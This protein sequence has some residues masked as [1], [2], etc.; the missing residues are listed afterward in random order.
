MKRIFYPNSIVV[1]GVSENPDNLARNI[2]FNLKAFNYQGDLYAVGRRDGK[3]AGITIESTLDRIPDGL[4]LAVI[5]TPAETVPDLMEACGRKGIQRV[6][7]ESSGFSEFSPE[8]HR[9]E[10]QLKATARRWD[11]RFVG[12]NCISVVNLESGVCLPFARI[13]PDAVRK[14]PVSIVSQSGGISITYFDRLSTVGVGVN[15]VVSIGNKA[16][17]D[18]G[19]Y[20]DYLL[21][22]PGTEIV[23]LYL[24]SIQDGRRLISQA[25]ASEKPIIIHKA[26]RGTASQAVAFSH[27]AALADDDRVVSAAFK[28]AGILRSDTIPE[29][30]MIARGLALPPVRG[31]NLAVISRSG[32]H[33]VVAAD[34][35]ERYDFKLA[36]L[37]E[38]FTQSVR[39]MFRADVI[40]LTNPIDLGVIFDFDLYAQIVEQCLQ[41][42]SP[43][44]VLLVN[45]YGMR[46][47]ESAHRLA[48]RV[49]AIM[50]KSG[51]P[52]A[53]CT[54]SRTSQAQE[55]RREADMPVFFD[56]ETAVRALA[57][58]RDWHRWK[59]GHARA[60]FIENLTAEPASEEKITHGTLTTDNVFKLCQRAGIAVAPWEVVSEP[61]HA[62]GA[63]KRLGFPVVLKMLAEEVVHK[64]DAGG[65]ILDLGDAAE[66]EQG[67]E[68]IVQRFRE[69]APASHLPRILVQ[70][71]IGEG[72]EVILGAKR[73]ASFGP[74]VMFGMG[75]IHVE[76]FDDVS[77]RVAPLTQIDAEAMIDEVR[78]S[79]VLDG[80][81]GKL[82]AC[83]TALVEALLAISAL[84]VQNPLLSEFEINPL[85]VTA[86]GALAVD[87]RAV[88]GDSA[89]E[90]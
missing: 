78:G 60:P 58:S 8:G 36:P 11:I 87:A 39:S 23:C 7:I 84:M 42:I 21:Q 86:D 82:P 30:V 2:I 76:I 57:A 37:P 64:T 63:A 41:A 62:A 48:K 22:D 55:L 27:T 25:R 90:E 89:S 65:V 46:E 9:L 47:A 29:T 44:A 61:H 73:D 10:E 4:D 53:F 74:V 83:R 24:E 18:E 3:I 81:R 80:V 75:G 50:K 45:T 6:V 12:P 20:L 49:Q 28:Q 16:D 17:L 77:F 38:A 14:G 40:S 79:R 70:S 54:Y 85:I 68:A 67:A 15:K 59:S 66:V 31:D 51:R 26:N 69:L 35:A 19:D 34:T 32:G 1:I 88:A 33:A 72:V 52:I 5:L 43:D 71:M 13:T 56:V